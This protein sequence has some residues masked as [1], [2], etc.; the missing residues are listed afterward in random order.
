MGDNAKEEAAMTDPTQKESIA[1]AR[2]RRLQQLA[3]L[4]A[5]IL[6]TA[7]PI[8]GTRFSIGLDPLLGL[9]PGVGDALA[10]M[11]GTSILF[12]AARLNV[13][14][15]VMVRMCLNLLLNGVLGAVPGLGDAFSV[16]FQSNARN[17][18]LLRRVSSS[19]RA[20]TATDWAFVLGLLLG[21]LLILLAAIAAVLWVIARLWVR[22]WPA[23][24]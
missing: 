10:G 14:R 13:P 4:L 1:D 24:R 17:A 23:R 19:P 2:A 5:R 12:I 16:W 9:I 22:P 3:D 20:S 18:A 6:D 7:I 8:P 11:V 21:T 15:I